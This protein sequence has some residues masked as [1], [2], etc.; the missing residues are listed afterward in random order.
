MSSPRLSGGSADNERRGDSTCFLFLGSP[1]VSNRRAFCRPGLASTER[2][3]GMGG[4][5]GGGEGGGR[6]RTGK[7]QPSVSLGLAKLGTL[8]FLA[9]TSRDYLASLSFV[10]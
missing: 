8:A 5:G 3:L 2:T 1:F 10:C 7:V 9:C 4:A 6:G